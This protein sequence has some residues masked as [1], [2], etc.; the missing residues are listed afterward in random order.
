MNYQPSLNIPLEP[1]NEGLTSQ[2]PLI[3]HELS[4]GQDGRGRGLAELSLPREAPSTTVQS[5][6]AWPLR[7]RRPLHKQGA[8]TGSV[9][10][11]ASAQA[12]CFPVPVLHFQRTKRQ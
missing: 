4:Q 7:E 1:S 10:H 6:V 5:A 12:S 3:N 2:D 9:R 8:G 11:P